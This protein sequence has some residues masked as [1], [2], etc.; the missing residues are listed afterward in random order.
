M[1]RILR[2]PFPNYSPP[3]PDNWLPYVFTSLDDA[4]EAF[5]GGMGSQP[6][7]VRLPRSTRTQRDFCHN[8]RVAD[9]PGAISRGGSSREAKMGHF[10]G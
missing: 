5:S 1:S 8:F 2:H 3:R 7:V 10:Y 4:S 9:G 6:A